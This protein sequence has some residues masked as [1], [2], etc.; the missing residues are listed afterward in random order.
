MDESKRQ[1]KGDPSL[2]A[3]LTLRVMEMVLPWLGTFNN[4]RWHAR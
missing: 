3:C 1:F 2:S 4:I